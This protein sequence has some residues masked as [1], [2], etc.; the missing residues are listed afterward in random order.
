MVELSKGKSVINPKIQREG[1]VARLKE[2]RFS[3]KIINPDFLLKF[4]E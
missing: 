4:N 3:F 2:K 1:I